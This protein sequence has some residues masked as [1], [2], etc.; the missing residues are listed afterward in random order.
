MEKGPRL[1]MSK[2]KIV[3]V[4]GGLAGLAVAAYVAR[5]RD[6]SVHVLERS[7][8]LGGRA[9]TTQRDGFTFNL[10][11]HALYRKGEAL[12]VLR[13]LEVPVPGGKPSVDGWA[14]RAGSLHRLPVNTVSL[15]ATTLFGIGGKAAAGT[16]LARVPMLDAGALAG[17][18]VAEWLDATGV[19][20]DVRSVLEAFLRLSSYA[21]A[22]HLFSAETAVRQ[23]Q[24]AFA[25]VVYVDGGWQTLVAG[26]ASA[27]ERRGVTIETGARVDGLARE[28][29]GSYALRMSDGR[30][31]AC[32]EL[33]LAVAPNEVAR[34]L[35]S[36]GV[37]VPDSI[38]RTV[39]VRMATLDI[40]L[41]R[42]PN[43]KNRFVL[44]I[45][46]PLY[47]SVHSAV[48]KLAPEGS[49]LL[50]VGKYLT[51]DE[52]DPDLDRAELETLLDVAQP[53]WRDVVVHSEY[54]PR[55]VVA[56]RLDLAEE[57]GAAGRPPFEMPNL[58]GVYLAGDWVQGGSWLSDASLGSA[59]AVARAIAARAEPRKAVA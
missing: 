4:G 3:V 2:T 56:E 32:D 16:W 25:N 6:F 7:K 20:G 41:S 18:S 48:A 35:E 47:L 13:E 45:D 26:L 31:V 43:P 5:A 14:Y 46:R 24:K 9:R 38:T 8:T 54:L 52:G 53:G 39:P 30:T 28:P 51:G 59:R 27:A 10:G 33:V 50:H 11:P 40:G 34:L 58:P 37:T 55:M 29:D 42:L 21:N 49:A 15:L 22:P 36:T 12:E 19:R 17:R 57:N 23:F 44:G 1:S